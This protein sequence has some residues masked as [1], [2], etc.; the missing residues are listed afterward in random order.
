MFPFE[1]QFKYSIIFFYIAYL[2]LLPTEYTS[3]IT[4]EIIKCNDD[5]HCHHPMTEGRWGFSADVWVC[6]LT[7]DFNGVFAIKAYCLS[8]HT[9]HHDE[10]VLMLFDRGKAE[11]YRTQ[12]ISVEMM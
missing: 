9:S 5:D 2:G 4:V 7:P 8:S 10:K 3:D 1:Y 11:L 6:S 12:C